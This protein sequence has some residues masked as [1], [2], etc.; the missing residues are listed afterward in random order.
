VIDV[1]ALLISSG[2]E[3]E[4]DIVQFEVFVGESYLAVLVK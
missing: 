2:M 3:E 4:D 1:L